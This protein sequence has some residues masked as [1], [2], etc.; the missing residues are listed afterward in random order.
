MRSATVSAAGKCACQLQ[1]VYRSLCQGASMQ[2]RRCA[3]ET[4]AA[5]SRQLGTVMQH[6][7]HSR[8][9]SATRVK[10]LQLIPCQNGGRV[11]SST[12][13]STH[14]RHAREPRRQRVSKLV[15]VVL[16]CSSHPLPLS[17]SQRAQRANEQAGRDGEWR[18]VHTAGT[19]GAAVE[20]SSI[21]RLRARRSACGE[22]RVELSSL[23]TSPPPPMP[24]SRSS[25]GASSFTSATQLSRSSSEIFTREQHKVC[26][27]A[28]QWP[29]S[30]GLLRAAGLPG[31][32]Q[33]PG[34]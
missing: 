10:Q 16:P 31:T 21:M 32:V 14:T 24:S 29:A 18:G 20:C 8:A 19:A 2:C 4:T 1:P 28:R 27:Q 33:R 13:N 7:T 25:H 9:V 22:R 23:R 17:R 34:R 12:H 6:R 30:N 11:H 3:A 5:R 15:I 26:T